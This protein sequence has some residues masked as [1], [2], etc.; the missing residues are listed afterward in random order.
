LR[1]LHHLPKTPQ[2]DL[3][4]RRTLRLEILSRSLPL[5]ALD[6]F[7]SPKIEKATFAFISCICSA[8]FA[9][10]SCILSSLLFPVVDILPAL[11]EVKDFLLRKKRVCRTLGVWKM[12][13]RTRSDP[14]SQRQAIDNDNTEDKQAPQEAYIAD[15]L[16]AQKAKEDAQHKANLARHDA[17]RSAKNPSPSKLAKKRTSRKPK[18]KKDKQRKYDSDHTQSSSSDDDDDGEG[19]Q[20]QRRN[21]RSKSNSP[22][23]KR[24]AHVSHPIDLI[25]DAALVADAPPE[26]KDSQ[27][28]QPPK[29]AEEKAKPSEQKAKDFSR[30]EKHQAE[31]AE[32]QAKL[33]AKFD[34]YRLDLNL[35]LSSKE[36]TLLEK[37]QTLLSQ[38]L[39]LE[40]KLA[41]QQLL[42]QSKEEELKALHQKTLLINQ[43]LALNAQTTQPSKKRKAQDTPDTQQHNPEE[44][45]DKR[46][47]R[48]KTIKNVDPV[49]R[50][51]FNPHNSLPDPS[52]QLPPRKLRKSPSSFTYSK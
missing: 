17:F 43:I 39:D 2:I 15:I 33:E 4:Q 37:E 51:A 35:Q 30:S 14:E 47:K 45:Q 8:A 9:F 7:G 31:L 23:R 24:N 16:T 25:A 42:L 11:W 22:L 32:L 21:L 29:P 20:Y 5:F 41:Q 6:A 13:K 49:L 18:Q 19:Q 34:S 27:L 10:L 40:H 12:K 1:S 50:D 44:K 36:Q 52:R 26:Q 38:H 3:S 48:R 46:I 28:L